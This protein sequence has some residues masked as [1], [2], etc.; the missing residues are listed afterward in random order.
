MFTTTINTIMIGVR[1]RGTCAL[2][3]STVDF[4]AHPREQ[5]ANCYFDLHDN[6]PKGLN[7]A[8]DELE[9]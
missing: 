7:R 6:N 9:P 2:S 4:A 8:A 1:F 3:V 5:F